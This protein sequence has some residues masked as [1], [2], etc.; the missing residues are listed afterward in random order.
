VRKKK[1]PGLFCGF[2]LTPSGKKIR[3]IRRD[4]FGELYRLWREH[5]DIRLG[6]RVLG[7]KDGYAP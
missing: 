4:E 5:A 7:M 3:R 1:S 6:V 2:W